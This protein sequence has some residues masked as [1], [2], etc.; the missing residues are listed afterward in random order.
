M[1]WDRTARDG[2]GW[3]G[4]DRYPF[5]SGIISA[6]IYLFQRFLLP[7]PH[8]HHINTV[9]ILPYDHIP[10][11]PSRNKCEINVEE[12]G[13]KK[14]RKKKKDEEKDEGKENRH[15]QNK[16]SPSPN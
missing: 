2:M 9:V 4:N 14:R 3:D 11:H 1:G 12:K 8:R 15:T 7:F 5:L 10:H 6:N 13:R 16:D